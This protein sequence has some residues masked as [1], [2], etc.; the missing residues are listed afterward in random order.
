MISAQVNSLK[1]VEIEIY[2]YCNRRCDFCPNSL[3]TS[4]QDKKN[5]T[6]MDFELF[7]KTIDEL[8]VLNY[9]GVISFSRYNEPLAFDKLTKKYVDYVKQ[10]TKNKVVANTNGDFLNKNSIEIFD[11]LTVMDYSGKSPYWWQNRMSK[12]NCNYIQEKSNDEFL[13]FKTPN[14]KDILLFLDFKKN[15]TVEDRGGIIQ[16]SIV[17]FKNNK[18]KRQRPCF[19]PQKFLGIDYNGHVTICCNMNSEFHLQH[20]IGNTFTESISDILSSSKRKKYI[21]IMSSENFENYLD[22]CKFCQKDPGRYTRDNPG[23]FYNGERK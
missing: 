3:V 19:E 11:E 23:I 20:T 15:A 6:I 16:T 22:S 10:R 17:K 4:R 18:D 2:N 13:F 12:L 9:S 5:P 7:K 21:E 14:N 1:L 8:V